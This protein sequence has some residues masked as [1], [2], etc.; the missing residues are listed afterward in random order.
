ME[1]SGTSE[2]DEC[3]EWVASARPSN[4][5]G[6]VASFDAGTRRDIKNRYRSVAAQSQILQQLYGSRLSMTIAVWAIER[7]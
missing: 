2:I 7:C 3:V 4:E 6:G 5:E 1:Q